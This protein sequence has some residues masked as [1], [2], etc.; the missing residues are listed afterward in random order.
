MTLYKEFICLANSRKLS[1]RCVAGKEVEKRTWIRPISD[2]Q[3]GELLENQIVYKDGNFPKILDIIR[4]PIQKWKLKIFQPENMLVLKLKWEKIGE[5]P[6]EKI[7]ELCDHPQTLWI[8]M[9]HANDRVPLDYLE[10]NKITN[11][12]YLIKPDF[13]KIMREDSKDKVGRPKKRTKALFVYNNVP[14]ILWITDPGIEN[15]FNKIEPG[16]Y[17]LPLGQVYL[18]ISLSEPFEGFC[19]KLVAA[20]IISHSQKLEKHELSSELKNELFVRLKKWRKVQADKENLPPYCIAHDRSLMKIVENN[21]D[22]K[23]ELFE[24]RGFGKKRVE[25]YGEQIIEVVKSLQRK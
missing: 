17:D 25:K 12:L 22:S 13:I 1:G 14:Y 2:S 10:K 20:I 8:N 21:V 9:S 6:I 11:S 19:Y 4:I 16:S 3:T 15:E 18:C 24:I 5:F 7:D 23:D